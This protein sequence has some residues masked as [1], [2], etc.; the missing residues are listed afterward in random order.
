MQHV[1]TVRCP[2]TAQVGARKA[3]KIACRRVREF[4]V[5]KLENFTIA[6]RIFVFYC[7]VFFFLFPPISCCNNNIII[8]R[9]LP[10][11]NNYTYYYYYFYHYYYYYYIREFHL[12]VHKR[13]GLVVVTVDCV[14]FWCGWQGFL[15]VPSYFIIDGLELFLRSP[16]ELITRLEVRVT[17]FARYCCSLHTY[18]T[19]GM[20]TYLPISFYSYVYTYILYVR[21]CIIPNTAHSTYRLR[22][23]VYCLSSGHNNS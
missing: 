17:K 2:L 18:M 19:V 7:L 10:N 16:Y 1:P 13:T 12:A 15:N 14:S 22:T 8:G 4:M 21:I 9:Y 5:V 11:D 6:T 3:Q 20:C 23:F